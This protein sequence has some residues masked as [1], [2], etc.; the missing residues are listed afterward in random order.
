MR[1][2]KMEELLTRRNVLALGAQTVFSAIYYL[3]KIEPRDSKAIA[4]RPSEMMRSSY[5]P[6]H[7]K[8]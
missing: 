8:D 6:A 2:K 7:I 5:L 3:H 4:N 1:V